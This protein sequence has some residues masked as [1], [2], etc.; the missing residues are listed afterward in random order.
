MSKRQSRQ[1]AG[2]AGDGRAK[3][4]A[5]GS[6]LSTDIDRAASGP[7]AT[8]LHSEKKKATDVER[9]PHTNSR[10]AL[11]QA[12]EVQRL[13]LSRVREVVTSNVSLLRDAEGLEAAGADIGYCCEV[14]SELL[15]PIIGRLGL[16]A[17]DAKQPPENA[18]G[19]AQHQLY[20][21]HS[22]TLVVAHALQAEQDEYAA[23]LRLVFVAIAKMMQEALTALDPVVLSIPRR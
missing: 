19:E 10:Q 4:P 8:I 12:I 7:A 23:N 16:L 2:G 18:I 11:A 13:N 3:K 14:I 17:A 6:A 21:V 20:R 5:S 1:K 22:V 9:P 15:E